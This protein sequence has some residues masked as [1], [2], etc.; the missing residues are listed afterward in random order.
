MAELDLPDSTNGALL[1]LSVAG[2]SI[3]VFYRETFL[4]FFLFGIVAITGSIWLFFL[5]LS[6]F[7]NV[8]SLKEA[9]YDVRSQYKKFLF[10]FLTVIFIIWMLSLVLL[11]SLR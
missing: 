1:V 3:S 6:I 5:S 4:A 7:R 9:G 2:F 10:Q 11:Q 8:Q